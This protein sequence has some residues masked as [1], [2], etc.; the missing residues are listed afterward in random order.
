M[1][2]T[3]LLLSGAPIDVSSGLVVWLEVVPASLLPVGIPAGTYLTFVNG[4]REAVQGTLAAV[5]ALL[6]G[7]PPLGTVGQTG[8]APLATCSGGGVATP[9]GTARAMRIGPRVLLTGGFVFVPAIPGVMET[10]TFSL[11][12]A[13]EVPLPTPFSAADNAGGP[14]KADTPT[15]TT[16]A[17]RATVGATSAEF[18]ATVVGVKDALAFVLSYDAI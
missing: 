4:E 12:N 18:D 8:Y 1:L 7:A 5:A 13:P 15:T 14:V 3:L 16:T 6:S 17:L 9:V 2:V 11:A 10:I